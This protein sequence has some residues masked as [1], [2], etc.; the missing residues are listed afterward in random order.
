MLR[1]TIGLLLIVLAL[2][3]VG[4]TV[5]EFI[6]SNGEMSIW[7]VN[8]L[9]AAAFHAAC[10]IIASFLLAEPAPRIAIKAK[11]A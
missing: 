3:C 2:V 9:G 10:M 11:E 5:Y 1:K 6:V 7:S 8:V 4:T